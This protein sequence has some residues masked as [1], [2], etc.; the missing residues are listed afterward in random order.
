MH[1]FAPLA[2]H[3]S[4]IVARGERHAKIGIVMQEH[5]FVVEAPIFKA[6][7][8]QGHAAIGARRDPDRHRDAGDCAANHDGFARDFDDS[9][10]IV[11]PRIVG[12]ETRPLP[13][14]R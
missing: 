13:S 2:L 6:G 14:F 9:P 12:F 1:P 5:R 8:A 10:A 3:F 7:D 11:R 4:S